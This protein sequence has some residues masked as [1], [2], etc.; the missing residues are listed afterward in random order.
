MVCVFA[1]IMMCNLCEHACCL[2]ILRHSCPSARSTNRLQSVAVLPL[3]VTLEMSQQSGAQKGG[4]RSSSSAKG[5]GRSGGGSRSGKDTVA[6]AAAKVRVAAPTAIVVAI[7]GP[8][9]H[10]QERGPQQIGRRKA[11]VHPVRSTCGRVETSSPS[12]GHRTRKALQRR[13]RTMMSA[14]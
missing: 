3:C 5:Y 13:W 7:R 11:K 10:G 12:C 4:M 1:V 14:G 9:P 8:T 2:L 6:S